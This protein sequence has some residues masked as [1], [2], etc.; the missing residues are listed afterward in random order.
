M[1]RTLLGGPTDSSLWHWPGHIL[2]PHSGQ[3]PLTLP[4]RL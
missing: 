1:E 4:V 3:T 2:V